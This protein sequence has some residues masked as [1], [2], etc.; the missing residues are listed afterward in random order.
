MAV[1]IRRRR[2]GKIVSRKVMGKVYGTKLPSGKRIISGG[3]AQVEP[4][5]E[6]TTAVDIQKS[7]FE[8]QGF[9]VTETSDKL[10]LQKEGQAPMAVGKRTGI[11]V[12]GTSVGRVSTFREGTPRQ[13]ST[14]IQPGRQIMIG[15]DRPKFVGSI[16]EEPTMRGALEEPITDRPISPYQKV[17]STFETGLEIQ[18]FGAF[19]AQRKRLGQPE[20]GA[21]RAA[22]AS[23]A[24]SQVALGGVALVGKVVFRPVETTIGIAKITGSTLGT[25]GVLGKLTKDFSPKQ[26]KKTGFELKGVSKP[27]R[28]VGANLA[29]GFETQPLLTTGSLLATPLIFGGLSKGLGASFKGV[30]KFVSRGQFKPRPGQ[31]GGTFMGKDTLLAMKQTTKG[32]VK[33]FQMKPLQGAGQQKLIYEGMKLPRGRVILRESM[34]AERQITFQGKFRPEVQSNLFRVHVQGMPQPSFAKFTESGVKVFGAR[35]GLQTKMTDIFI[36]DP[37]TFGTSIKPFNMKTTPFI[38][39]MFRQKKASAFGSSIGTQ[40]GTFAQATTTFV[41]QAPL[42]QAAPAQTLVPRFKTVFRP[43]ASTVGLGTFTGSR[44]DIMS[45]PTVRQR[46]RRRVIVAP[47]AFSL[48]STDIRSKINTDTGIK[49]VV[50]PIIDTGIRGKQ[51]QD[52]R[53][54]IIPITTPDMIVTPVPPAPPRPPSL[55]PPRPPPRPPRKPPKLLSDSSYLRRRKKKGRGGTAFIRPFKYTASIVPAQFNIKG[56]RP[57]IITGLGRRP[58]I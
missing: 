14:L 9:K 47:I 51:G 7:L 15:E 50:T 35:P 6:Q 58:L 38:I 25:I 11:Q 2:G 33:T 10:I 13:V 8:K 31:V 17:R 1:V 55:R 45:T 19:E 3:V 46:Q 53:Q 57:K 49:P 52:V 28:D 43:T 12:T 37:K 30:G 22:R 24:V 39:K 41:H 42:R 27:A 23:A 32:G 54:R 48:P 4:T 26:I 56:M 36:P 16:R 40:R 34:G 5:Q 21:V 29:K 20:T 44:G 18:S